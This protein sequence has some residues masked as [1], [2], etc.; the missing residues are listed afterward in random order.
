M[1]NWHI[2][3]K[4]IPWCC[5]GDLEPDVSPAVRDALL[6]VCCGQGTKEDALSLKAALAEMGYADWDDIEIVRNAC[7][8]RTPSQA[9]AS[10][11]TETPIHLERK[12]A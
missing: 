7:E 12:K 9:D 4:G 10:T 2:S 1:A 11:Q 6:R 5:R 3:I 8:L